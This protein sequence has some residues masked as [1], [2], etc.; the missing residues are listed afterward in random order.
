MSAALERTRA[1]ILLHGALALSGLT[2]CATVQNA[3][4]G[5]AERATGREVS[6]RVDRAVDTAAETAEDAALGRDG[7]DA[8]SASSGS[9]SAASQGSATVEPTPAGAGQE[10]TAP[11]RE[12]AVYDFE[13]GERTLVHDDLS[14]ANMGDFPQSLHWV[15]GNLEVVELDGVRFLRAAGRN[16]AFSIPLPE[17]L[18]DRFTIEMDVYNPGAPYGLLMTTGAMPQG[19]SAFRGEPH[20][21]WAAPA[22]GGHGLKGA[23]GGN[24]AVVR[25]DAEV[26]VTARVMMDGKHLKLYW[27]QERIANVPRVELPRSNA[28]HF[29]IEA[30]PETPIYVGSFRVAAGGRDLYS[31]LEREG[32]FTADGIEFDSGSDR[33]RPASRATLDEIGRMLSE[34]AG[35][36]VSIEGHTDSQGADAAN[37]E[38]SQRRAA[39]VRRY[40]MEAHGIAGARLQAEGHGESRP[41]AANDTEEGRQQNRRVEIVRRDG[42]VTGAAAQ[43]DGGPASAGSTAPS[44][45]RAESAPASSPQGPTTAAR[46]TDPTRVREVA[47][48]G[49]MTVTMDGRT[50]ELAAR[51]DWKAWQNADDPNWLQFSL[52]G[53]ADWRLGTPGVGVFATYDVSTGEMLRQW[54]VWNNALTGTTLDTYQNSFDGPAAVTVTRWEPAPDDHR[55][56]SGTFELTTQDGRTM[57][58]RFDVEVPKG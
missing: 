41:V 9:G 7:E 26:P 40:L 16:A 55:R 45:D 8:A 22:R 43:S 2:A 58:G 34:H 1:A 51:G 44:R 13:A 54:R 25:M 38:L 18:P 30:Y 3:A 46:A 21:V 20:L 28:I 5:A 47:T 37:E 50:D 57:S 10:G 35:L 4:Q 49:T 19:S 27:G 14:S 23:D 48:H 36:S 24:L 53:G 52:V 12:S 33:I 32:R 6:E 42:P 31:V 29:V 15:R 39:S 56:I 11:P 17:T